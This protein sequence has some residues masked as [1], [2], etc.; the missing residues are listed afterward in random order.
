MEYDE[1]AEASKEKKTFLIARAHTTKVYTV[2]RSC[3]ILSYMHICSHAEMA[4]YTT[5]S[6]H[7]HS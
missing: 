1:G 5:K 4:L 7:I 3:Y 2:R 6:V